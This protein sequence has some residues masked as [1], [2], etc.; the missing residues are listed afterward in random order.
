M[1][2]D[3]SVDVL[4]PFKEFDETGSV[5]WMTSFEKNGQ[6]TKGFDLRHFHPTVRPK[7]DLTENLGVM[8]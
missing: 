5:D 8:R 1:A 2:L 4:L 7:P 6:R 3:D